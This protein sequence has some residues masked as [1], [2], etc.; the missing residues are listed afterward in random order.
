METISG[1]EIAGVQSGIAGDAMKC[2]FC[3]KPVR[4]GRCIMVYL[5]GPVCMDCYPALLKRKGRIRG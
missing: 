4:V 2:K 3:G 5:L 1:R